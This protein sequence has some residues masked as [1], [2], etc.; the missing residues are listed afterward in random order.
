MYEIILTNRAKKDFNSF[1]DLIKKKIGKKLNEY[2]SNPF[3]YAKK[4][5]DT[6]LGSFRFRIGNYRVVFDVDENKIIVLRI[7]HRKDIYK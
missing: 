3:L 2:A 5:S 1:D 4:L 7:G 6:N